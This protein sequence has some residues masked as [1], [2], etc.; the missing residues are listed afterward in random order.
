MGGIVSGLEKKYKREREAYTIQKSSKEGN[1]G[2]REHSAETLILVALGI[3]LEAFLLLLLRGHTPR[4]PLKLS[5][6][7][8][9]H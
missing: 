9:S 1:K 2:S 8:I 3:V 7:C 4:P 6:A 5:N